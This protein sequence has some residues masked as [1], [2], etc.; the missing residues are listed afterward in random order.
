MNIGFES[1]EAAQREADKLQVE[2]QKRWSEWTDD[3]IR[4]KYID[5]EQMYV[6]IIGRDFKVEPIKLRAL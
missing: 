3:Q 6:S 4:Q 1:P 2:Y 5:G